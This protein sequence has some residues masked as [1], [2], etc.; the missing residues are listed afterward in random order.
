MLSEGPS[1]ALSALLAASWKRALEERLVGYD[2]SLPENE[3]IVAPPYRYHHLPGRA[4]RPGA[5]RDGTPP[6]QGLHLPHVP[7]PFDGE[8]F[9]REREVGRV[10]RGGRG[11][12]LVCNRFPVTPLH[13]L[14]VRAA[15]APIETLPQHLHGP[16]EIEDM[17]HLLD[18]AGEP[19]HALFNSNRGAD[20][21]QSGSSVN[22][23]H[24]QLFPYT[25]EPR[26]PLATE[27][28]AV[29]SDRGSVRV[30]RI[31]SWPA[32]HVL[33]EGP[34]GEVPL[35]AEVLWDL[36]RPL[37]ARNTAYNIDL[38]V[39]SRRQI[40]ILLFP[41]RPA[42]AEEIPG[43]GTLSANFGGWELSGDF[44]IPTPEIMA[45]I[46]Q[47]PAAAER[48]TTKRLRETTR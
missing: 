17:L 28:P 20:D 31:E 40:R 8:T 15:T 2:P 38:G 46:R 16:V 24:F 6:S 37:N 29:L 11:Y 48:L 9:V 32:R 35:L 18:M 26:S 30:G 5:R 41:R 12:H 13:F 23:W 47:N 21:S 39:D 3:V 7:C 43:V 4:T 1:A 34:A 10:E 25:V 27:A 14:P 19:Y 36:V 44:V 22:H 42:P 33:I 45:W